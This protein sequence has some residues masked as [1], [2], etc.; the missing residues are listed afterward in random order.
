MAL[1]PPGVAGHSYQPSIQ[2]R[3]PAPL[4]HRS[5]QGGSQ[6]TAPIAAGSMAPDAM[7]GRLVSNAEAST[8]DTGEV[9]LR[10]RNGSL[11]YILAVAL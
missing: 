6:A 5:M 7:G 8:S 10:E 9:R 2:Q 1:P 11:P 4:S 3:S